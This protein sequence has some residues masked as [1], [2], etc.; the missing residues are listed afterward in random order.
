MKKTKFNLLKVAIALL[1]IGLYISTPVN[2]LQASSHREA[3]LIANDPLADNTDLYVFRSPDDTNTVTIIAA[4]IP[5]ELPQGGPNYYSFGEK[6]RYE[7]H[8]KN[9]GTTASDNITY[10][11]TFLQTN[12][13]TSTFFN[14]R[15]GKQNIKT[16]YLCQKSINGGAFF[17]ILSNGIVPPNN[18]GPRSISDL[19]LG[20]NTTYP[21]LMQSA[22]G[23]GC[24]G[25]KIY[26]GPA[27][28]PF[29]MDMG[30]FF[31]LG[32]TRAGG[33]GV[34]APKDGL[35]CKNV[36]VIAM[37]LPISHL[38]KTG[39][40]V[41]QAVNILDPDF[42][43]GVWASASRQRTTNLS[44]T[45]GKPATSGGWIQVSRIGMPFTNE[46]FIPIIKKDVWNSLTPYNE[47]F[48]FNKY[49]INPE[50]GL[51]MDNSQF[52]G[53]FPALTPLRI[54]SN[55]LGQFDFRNNRTGFFPLKGTSAVT[56]TAFDDAIFG[57]TLLPGNGQPRS[58]DLMLISMM[59]VPNLR[60]Y[61]L[62]V[63]KAANNPMAA[64]KP[65][66]NNFISFGDMLRLNMAVPVTPRNS[67][68]FSS[69]GLI[70]AA[71]KGLTDPAFANNTLQR[72]PNMDGF[73]NGRRLEDDVTRIQLQL[74]SGVFLAVIGA[75]YNDYTGA[76]PLIT[77]NFTGVLNYTTGI[78]NND[79][80][81][82]TSFPFVAEPW[83][84]YGLCEGGN[85]YRAANP[86]NLGLNLSAPDVAILQNY[87]NPA[88]ENTTFKYR[89]ASKTRVSI[90]ICDQEGRVIET[91]VNEKKSEGT[92]EFKYNVG[93]LP[94][95]IYFAT[96]RDNGAFIQA[97]KFIVEK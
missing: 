73:P 86:N 60:P 88:K 80:P 68:D 72:I 49:F 37:K 55:S 82:S 89:L 83:S 20:L 81:F 41:D 67:P 63:N 32:Q 8:I 5:F 2:F 12:E 48:T 74:V 50:L 30:G 17:T 77:P 29:F 33:T 44:L 54:Q 24:H 56:G 96:I 97:V 16:T 69:E 40:T 53:F 95:G 19:V 62:A 70:A 46:M 14:I 42:I 15:F 51:Y 91:P 7:I 38:Q 64:G 28:D 26:C 93:K 94:N 6:I 47:L 35:H 45:G 23:T 61:Q 52:G 4:Y 75:A 21:S 13:D 22:I 34:N 84:G 43:I 39:K 31:D 92:Y 25:E 78:E 11:F 76:P 57:T 66:I 65:F 85:F 3:P 71:I 1:F 10:R 18:I 90:N 87:P 27:D 9:E 58:V 59:G 36:H 79:K